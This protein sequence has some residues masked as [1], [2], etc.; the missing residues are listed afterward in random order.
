[1]GYLYIIKH[2]KSNK[3]Y[4]GCKYSK[5]NSDPKELL[6]EGG[7]YTNSKIIKSLIDKDGLESF[8]IIAIRE[9]K[10]SESLLYETIFLRKWNIAN[11]SN[12]LNCHN[13]EHIIDKNYNITCKKY[14]DLF[15]IE[16]YSKMMSKIKQNYWDT[17]GNKDKWSNELKQKWDNDEFSNSKGVKDHWSK[18][19]N[20]YIKKRTSIGLNVRN[21]KVHSCIHCGKDNLTLGNLNRWHQD[22]CKKIKK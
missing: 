17:P 2:K 1:M 3:Y 7:Y 5:K 11:K 9:Y 6:K 10:N 14:K 22:N 15:T 18:Q 12:W 8:K 21:A 19:T 4:V 16:E 13:N 20:E